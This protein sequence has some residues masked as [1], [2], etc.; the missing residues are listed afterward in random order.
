MLIYFSCFNLECILQL[1]YVLLTWCVHL[2]KKFLCLW[3]CSF[4]FYKCNFKFFPRILVPRCFLCYWFPIRKR[5]FDVSVLCKVLMLR[6]H[7][8]T[9]FCHAFVSILP[10]HL[11]LLK[12]KFTL[13]ASENINMIMNHS[14]AQVVREMERFDERQ[15]G[16]LWCQHNLPIIYDKIITVSCI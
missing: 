1:D 8:Q 2:F 7:Q 15:V 4:Y 10:V 16:N 5:Q 12:E 9:I 6:K 11:S 3:V 13:N 14:E